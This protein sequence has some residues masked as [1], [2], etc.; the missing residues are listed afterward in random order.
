MGEGF[1]DLFLIAGERM[2]VSVLYSARKMCVC[3][4]KDRKGEKGG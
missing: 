2:S 1:E 3:E 4:N